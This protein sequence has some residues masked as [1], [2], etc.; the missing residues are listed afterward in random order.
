MECLSGSTWKP[1]FWDNVDKLLSVPSRLVAKPH[2][3]R[4]IGKACVGVCIAKDA[5][6]TEPH[7]IVKTTLDFIHNITHLLSESNKL[8]PIE[9][10]DTS[11]CSKPEGTVGCDF[12]V[13]DHVVS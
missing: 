10:R 1:I 9:P 11:R 8:I 3:S 6:S 13:P 4:D 12:D 5:F 2:L 7:H